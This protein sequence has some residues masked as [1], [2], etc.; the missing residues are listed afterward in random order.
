LVG[1]CADR[2]VMEPEPIAPIAD[3]NVFLDTLQARTFDFFWETTDHETGLT[4]DR[5]PNETFSSIAAIGFALP[6]YGVGVERGYVTRDEAAERTLNTLRFLW[7]RPQGTEQV[8]MTGYKGFFYHFL[9][10]D[11]GI[12]FRNTELSTIDTALLMSGVLFSREYFDGADADEAAIR[13]YADSLYQRVEWDWF[14]KQGAERLTMGWHPESDFGRAEWE[15]Y[16]EGMILYILGLGSPTY[17]LEEEVWDAWTSTYTWDDFYGYE[18]VNFSPLFG[19]QYSHIWVDFRGIQDAYMRE[20]GIDYF[21]NSRRATLGQREYA[22]DNP[23]GWADY[24]E[25]IWG[26][27]ACDGPIGREFEYNGEMRQFW[28][29]RA[30]GASAERIDDDGTI[31]PTAAGGSIPFAP[32]E[33][34]AALMEMHNRYGEALF[35]QYGFLDSFNP[36]FTFTDVQPQHGEV[37]GDSLWVDGDYL[38]IDQGP[39][40]LMAENHRTNFVWEVMKKSPY[41]VRGLQRAG[42]TGGWLDSLD[43]M[44]EPNVVISERQPDPEAAR[45]AARTIV[46]LG[47]STAEGTGPKESENTWVNRFRVYAKQQDPSLDV[48]NLARGGYTTHHLMPARVSPL[49]GRPAPDP[50]RNIDA[51]LVRDPVAIIINLP[52]ND[53]AAGFGLEE[54]MEN[55]AAMVSKAEAQGVPVWITTTQPRNLDDEWRQVQVDLKDTI[56]ETYGDHAIDFWTGIANEDATLNPVHDSGDNLHL[57]DDAHR[58]LFERVRDAG[59]V[60]AVLQEEPAMQ[61]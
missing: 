13:A 12:R 11:S 34:I 42:F 61:E 60:E 21:E 7:T 6:A 44:P 45:A 47:S 10:Y 48:L 8:G 39:I 35:Q 51:A 22:I 9:E 16:N 5:W 50:L 30:R 15:G 4:P 32:D 20:K 46:V 52:S 18:H 58:I 38:G 53:A 3:A 28:T 2:P 55:F 54:Q 25:N 49:E 23:A 19:H 17:P 14:R 40:L 59:V 56:L 29:Y 26:L 43:A 57:N 36:S 24:G 33:T 41:I 1:G 31:T 27:T 37:V